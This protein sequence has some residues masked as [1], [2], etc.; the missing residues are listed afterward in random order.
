MLKWAIAGL[1]LGILT[2]FLTMEYLKCP[3]GKYTFDYGCVK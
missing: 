2:G 3:E 1:I